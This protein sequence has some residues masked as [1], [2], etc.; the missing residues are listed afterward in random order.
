[1]SEANA[2]EYSDL[3]C[4]ICGKPVKSVHDGGEGVTMWLERFNSKGE[5]CG[6]RPPEVGGDQIHIH[7]M[8]DAPKTAH[9]PFFL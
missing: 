7:C 2:V 3:L 8:K 9:F 4:P 1:M 6:I 5:S